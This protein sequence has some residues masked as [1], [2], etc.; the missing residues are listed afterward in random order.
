M[1]LQV[2]DEVEPVLEF[3]VD[4]L[5]LRFKKGRLVGKSRRL[6]EKCRCVKAID[7]VFD[8]F[9]LGSPDAGV[10]N[11]DRVVVVGI[12]AEDRNAPVGKELVVGHLVLDF[13][14][15]RL[16]HDANRGVLQNVTAVAGRDLIGIDNDLADLSG[17]RMLHLGPRRAAHGKRS[18]G[19]HHR[20]G[21]RRSQKLSFHR[22]TSM[23]GRR[24]RRKTSGNVVGFCL[25]VRRRRLNPSLN[26]SL[27]G[28][29]LMH[30]RGKRKKSPHDLIHLARR[31]KRHFLRPVRTSSFTIA[32]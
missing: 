2:V 18:H 9:A 23:K 24:R 7:L 25:H 28:R 3:G 29:F 31:A 6:A 22:N 20:R 11:F 26:P 17:N 32:S 16:G 13:D 4:P 5:D 8:A 27:I 10:G 15:A 12:E 21:K 19:K 30:D 1:A 14:A